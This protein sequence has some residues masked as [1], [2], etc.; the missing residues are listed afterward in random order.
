MRLNDTVIILN[1]PPNS[2]KD[3]I[4]DGLSSR[5][6]FFHNRFKEHLYACTAYVFNI[7]VEEFKDLA[8]SRESKEIPNPNLL[9]P[10]ESYNSLE[11]YLKNSRVID[12]MHNTPVR[13]TPREALIFTSEIMIKPLMGKDYF[14]KI[15]SQNLDLESGTVASD[16]G[17]EDEIYP[18]IERVGKD[19]VFIIQFTREGADSFEGDS[20]GWVNIE[21]V[22][23]LV[24][25]NDSSI[26]D[27]CQRIYQFIYS[28][29]RKRFN[30]L[31]SIDDV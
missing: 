26:D 9:L 13:I 22:P 21:G 18:T 11:K 16:G 10:N 24:T 19:N 25:T 4:A 3:T 31:R 2:G 27:I 12:K 29:R 15:F 17:F 20:R 23:T 14:G 1:S 6:G 7:D 8:N 28:T 30:E 5:W